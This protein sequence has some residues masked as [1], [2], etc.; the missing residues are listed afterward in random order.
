M[1][2]LKAFIASGKYTLIGW[3]GISSCCCLIRR[4]CNEG[5]ST[6]AHSSSLNST[7]KRGAGDELPNDIIQR[8]DSI[9]KSISLIENAY[10]NEILSVLGLSLRD[11]Y[12]LPSC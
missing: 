2:P 5:K 10:F 7:G 9:M 1:L 8:M 3:P 6:A 11:V 4:R 12:V